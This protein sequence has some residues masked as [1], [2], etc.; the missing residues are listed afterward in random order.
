MF[1]RPGNAALISARTSPGN[2]DVSPGCKAGKGG[3]DHVLVLGRHG[4]K[5]AGDL[6]PYHLG[7]RSLQKFKL[8]GKGR[9][10]DSHSWYTA[11]QSTHVSLLRLSFVVGLYFCAS[12]LCGRLVRLAESKTQAS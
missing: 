10:E 1:A 2:S 8:I 7:I 4:D 5:M 3:S 9:G 6:L 12:A 11:S